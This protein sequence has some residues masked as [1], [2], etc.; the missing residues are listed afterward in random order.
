M[1]PFT[2]PQIPSTLLQKTILL[3]RHEPTSIIKNE[4][5]RLY[6]GFRGEMKLALLFNAIHFNKALPLYSLLFHMNDSEFQVDCLLLTTEIIYLL[7]VKNYTGNYYIEHDRL[8]NLQ[9]K[10][11]IANPFH[12]LERATFLFKKLLERFNIPLNVQSYI[13]FINE[14]FTLY[15]APT[16]LPIIFPTQIERFIQKI[17]ANHTALSKKIK[18][19]AQFLTSHHKEKTKYEAPHSYELTE[20]NKGIFCTSC[21]QKLKRKNKFYF[22]CEHCKVSTHLN[23]VILQAVAEFH[24]LFPDKKITTKQINEWCGNELSKTT[25]RR[26]LQQHLKK[27]SKWSLYE[28]C[29]S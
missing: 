1:E 18:S 24:T 20:L 15:Q 22:K 29:I 7:E 5:D 8:Y 23:T 21:T 27:S 26:V 16:H 19:V 14:Q 28:L 12:Q 11:E 10:R 25:V 2:S 9:T 13:V 17:N 4:Y 3:R 6:K